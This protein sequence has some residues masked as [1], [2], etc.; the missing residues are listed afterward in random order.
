[1]GNELHKQYDVP[2]D[3][4]VCTAG[5]HGLWKIYSA[6]KRSTKE[7]VS[8]FT[9]ERKEIERRLGPHRNS[10]PDVLRLLKKGVCSFACPAPHHMFA[11]SVVYA[12]H[13]NS[14]AVAVCMESGGANGPPP[15]H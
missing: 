11:V 12:S 8:I 7:Q 10:V 4:T 3:G 14:P 5:P 6:V 9:A 2:P 15:P 1:M 13:R